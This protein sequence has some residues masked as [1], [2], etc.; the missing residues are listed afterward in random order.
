M[1]DSKADRKNYVVWV[2]LAIALYSLTLCFLKC[3]LFQAMNM[4][5]RDLA[6][7]DQALWHLL[8]HG[9]LYSSLV[10]ENI[11]G[12]HTSFILYLIAPLYQ[13]YC[14]PETLV[15]VQSLMIGLGALPVYYIAAQAWHSQRAGLIW[16]LSYLLFPST[17]FLNMDG[18][19]F[20]FHP[21][22]FL[23]FFYLSLFLFLTQKR[24]W[25]CVLFVL[26]CLSVK[27]DAAITVGAIGLYS[28]I[29]NS[30]RPRA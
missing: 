12:E 14:S 24:R 22:A 25:L 9:Q 18:V 23:P 16:A 29:K 30:R 15:C 3:R 13:L 27:E 8:N 11:L 4:G 7:F 5:L 26:L 19:I 17:G 28:L 20:G 10:G 6:I 2:W 21:D 1:D